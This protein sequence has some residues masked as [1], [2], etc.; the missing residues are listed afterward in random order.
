MSIQAGRVQKLRIIEVI[1]NMKKETTDEL[2]R[3]F[4]KLIHSE[5]ANT[6]YQVLIAIFGFDHEMPDFIEEMEKQLEVEQLPA[7]KGLLRTAIK[8]A[9]NYRD[10]PEDCY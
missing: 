6:R 10:N 7:I 3:A 1:R 5:N 9:I 4:V 8:Y 2:Y